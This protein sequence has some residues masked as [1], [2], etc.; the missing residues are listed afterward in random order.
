MCSK[1]NELNKQIIECRS[2]LSNV[3]PSVLLRSIHAKIQALNCKLFHHL[4]QT[5][6]NKLE[7]LTNSP[8]NRREPL[9]NQNHHTVVTIPENLPLSNAEKSVLSKGLNFVPISKKSDE[10]TTRQDVEKFLCRVQLKAFF[11]NKEDKSDKTEKDAFE[12]LTAKKS[13]WTPPEG[14]FAS[15]DY[16]IKKCRHDVHKLKSNCN[17]KLSNLSKEEWTALVNLKNRNDLVIK[18]ADKGGAT[19]VWRTDLYQQEAIRQL[20]DPTSYTK[21]NKDLTPANQ[22]VVKDTIQELITKQELPVTAQNLIITTPRT[23]CIYFKPKIHK[24]NS[25]GRPIVSACSCPTELIS[26][27]LDKV[28]TPIVKS[29]PSYI[30]DSNHALEIFR[31]FNFSGENKIIFTMDI[32]SLY[33]VIPNNEGLQTLK[34]F[35]N[36]RPI[37]KPS[38]ETLLRLAELVLTLNCFSFGDNYCKQINSVAMG[39][40]M[41]PSYANLFV[42]FIENKLKNNYHGPKPDLYKRYIDDCIGATSSSK[43]ELNLSINSVNSFHPAL[44]YTWEISENSLAFLDIKLSIND[45][46]LSTS[47]HYKPTDSHN[48]L[49]HSSSHPQHVKNAIPFSQFLRLRRLC[50]DDT[51]FNNKCEEMCHFFK[52]RGYPDSAVNTG[53]HRAQEIDRETVLQTSQNEETDRIPFT[54]TYHPQNLAIKN[55]ILKNFEILSNDPETKHIFSLPPLISFKR[56]KNLGNFLVRSAFKFNNKPGT[57][58]CKRTRCKTCPFISNTVNISGPN[59]FV[60]V[61]DHFTCISS[62]VIYCITCTLCKKIYIGET[63]RRLADRFREHLRDAERNNTDASKPVARHFNLPNHSHHN[64][65]ICGLYLHHG[66]T[67]SRKN[68]EQKLIFQLGTLS[69]HGINECLS[70]H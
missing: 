66:N 28:M 63:G 20:S 39:T 35:F 14:Q 24:P 5:K 8:K 56:D 54:L 70:F 30:K 26:S 57:F 58:T 12:T 36:Q 17:T 69:P 40:K 60:K 25:P 37:K 10:F 47:V 2:Q 64:M 23:S 62:N 3:C 15:I 45:N 51:D 18:A 19:V 55:V 27:Y 4:E 16:F 46:G 41:G 42:G 65:T 38:S 7:N 9:E 33:T 21:V 13:K 67:E 1:R 31:N 32:T 34:Y 44:K 50:S 48:Y 49:L 52:K 68:L 22:K 59:R 6:K 43:E 11:H 53:K 29:L 61:T